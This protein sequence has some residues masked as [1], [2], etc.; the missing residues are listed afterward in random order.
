MSG[1][2][3]DLGLCLSEN[4]HEPDKKKSEAA[5]QNDSLNVK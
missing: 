4:D 1:A 3:T 5:G 2:I